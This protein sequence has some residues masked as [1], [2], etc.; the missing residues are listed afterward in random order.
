MPGGPRERAGAGCRR[1]ARGARRRCA[2]QARGAGARGAGRGARQVGERGLR[3]ELD[4]DAVAADQAGGA[5]LV[6][7][8]GRVQGLAAHVH[9]VVV[10]VGAAVADD[11]E[12][13]VGAGRGDDGVGRGDGGDDVLDDALPC[14]RCGQCCGACARVP[15]CLVLVVCVCCVRARAHGVRTVCL[16]GACSRWRR[17]RA[18]PCIAVNRHASPPRAHTHTHTH[19]TRTA[20]AP[21]CA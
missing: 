17:A 7:E 19:C 21:A 1:A 14:A 18:S 2:A 8:G 9:E 16:L 10:E 6:L 4:L 20:H 3:R 12:G 13:L 5:A 15:V 11:L